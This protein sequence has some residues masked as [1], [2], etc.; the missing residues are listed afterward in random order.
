MNFEK[1][2][3][4]ACIWGR[5]IY[6]SGNKKGMVGATTVDGM[7]PGREGGGQGTMVGVICGYTNVW[8]RLKNNMYAYVAPKK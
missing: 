3:V 5:E 4:C 8:C 7:Q 1:L 2:H 6:D